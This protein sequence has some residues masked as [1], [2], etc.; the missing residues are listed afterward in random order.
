MGISVRFSLCIFTVAAV[1]LC[2]A[3]G[4]RALGKPMKSVGRRVLAVGDS[5][6]L[7]AGSPG[8]YR[9]PLEKRLLS[10]GYR[11]QFVG[12][13]VENSQGL[14][15]PNHEGHGGWSTTDLING[16]TS[17]KSAGKLAQWLAA[18]RPETVVIMTGT[19]DD[20]WVT[21]QEWT[22]KYEKLLDVVFKFNPDTKV[23]LAAIPRSDN[24]VTGKAWAEAV[25]FDIVKSVVAKRRAKGQLV[26][27]ADTYTTF[28]AQTDLSDAYHPNA[29]GYRKIA[30]A[31]YGALVRK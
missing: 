17:Q 18:T 29:N 11:F 24:T 19:N 23:V 20:I 30:N 8:G 9:L 4:G 25:C 12:A 2:S 15:S 6:T 3:Q 28:N 14:T 10:E 22:A 31:I 21:K 1:A 7:G 27:F 13:S 5:I 26:T 16:K